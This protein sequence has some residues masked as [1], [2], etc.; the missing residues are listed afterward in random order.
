MTKAKVWGVLEG[1][2]IVAV[3]ILNVAKVPPFAT[4]TLLFVLPVA[5][6][7]LRLRRVRWRDLGLTLPAHWRRLAW[8]GA[9]GATGL[10]AL[11]TWVIEP[12]LKA[13]G[14]Q[15]PQVEGLAKLA[16]GGIAG[17]VLSILIGVVIGGLLE[18]MV[19]RGYMISRVGDA[20]GTRRGATVGVAL[21][22]L[23]FGLSHWYQGATGAIEAGLVGVMTG[24]GYVLT[25]G[26]LFLP[27]VVHAVG[28]VVG[29]ALLGIAHH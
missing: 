8:I 22:S 1:I 13:A 14:L 27:I 7:S 9:L 21:S 15:P 6:L 29:I 25:G 28:D 11:G 3:L 18:E 5:W 26:N 10:Q 17:F 20:I 12:A 16:S 23:Y 4:G 24:V 19:F 2:A